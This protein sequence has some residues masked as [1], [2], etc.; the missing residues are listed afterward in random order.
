VREG[1][2][3][4]AHTEDSACE[5]MDPCVVA[6]AIDLA[7]WYTVIVHHMCDA[8]Q[9]QHKINLKCLFVFLKGGW[10]EAPATTISKRFPPVKLQYL[11]WVLSRALGAAGACL[12][13]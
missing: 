10:C 5:V 6:R 11:K 12:A 7:V 1:I 9:T 8:A 3:A 2:K 13:R 4:G